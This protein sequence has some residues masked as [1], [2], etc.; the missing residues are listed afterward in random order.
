MVTAPFLASSTSAQVDVRCWRQDKCTEQ[1]KTRGLSDQEATLGFVPSAEAKAVC[2][3][4]DPKDDQPLGFCLPSTKTI[5]Q[6]SFGGKREFAHI[7]EFIQIIYRYGII[8]AG[9]MAVIVTL[10]GGLRITMSAGSPDK[11]TGGKK[12]IGGAV[13]GLILVALSYVI[14]YTVNPATVNLRLP[15]VWMVNKAGLAPQYCDETEKGVKL[16]ATPDGFDRTK[17]T[18]DQLNDIYKKAFGV[19]TAEKKDDKATSITNRR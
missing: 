7:G 3:D 5:T 8:F 18:T 4:K 19:E 10:I 12:M 17:Y 15:Q 2:G 9:I 11:V 13:G 1:R 6:I 16:V 14:L